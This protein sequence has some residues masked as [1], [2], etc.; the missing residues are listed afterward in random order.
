[1]CVQR[2][3]TGY[4]NAIVSKAPI[5]PIVNTANSPRTLA[6]RRLL[7]IGTAKPWYRGFWHQGAVSAP[8]AGPEFLTSCRGRSSPLRL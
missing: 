4:P 6:L 8:A 3:P 1:M 5:V 2:T 7:P